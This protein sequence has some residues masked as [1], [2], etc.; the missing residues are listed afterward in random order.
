MIYLLGSIILTSYL[1]L[2]FKVCGKLNIPVFPAIVFNYITCV[3]TG[4][5]V[6]GSFPIQVESLA[7]PWFRWAMI[8]GL[9]FITS[10]NLIGITAQK[11]GVAVASVANKLSLIIPVIL[12]IVLYNEQVV[13]WEIVGISLALIAVIFTCY[14]QK[15]ESDKTMP[16]PFLQKILLPLL[17]FIGSG[18]LDALIN[19][20]QQTYVTKETNNAF[21]IS[22][23]FSAASIGVIVLFYQYWKKQLVFK[24]NQIIAG[25]CIGI[26]NYFSIWCLVHFLQDSP[27]ETSASLPVNNMGIVLFSTLVAAIVFKE[28]LS[29]INWTGI[30]LSAIAIYLIAFGNT[31]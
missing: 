20:V 9:L 14:P 22:G 26:P 17:V 3:V 27:W 24:V 18:F 5:F 6:N 31:L 30:A 15:N 12:T 10:F 25:V 7:T 21:L 4:S 23:F 16:V 2:S 28:K 13:G 29:A 19:H 11:L 1:L 8:M